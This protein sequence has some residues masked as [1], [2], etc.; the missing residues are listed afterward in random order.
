MNELKV[1][2][3]KEILGNEFCIYGTIEEPLFLAKDIS[4]W[5]ENKNPSQMLSIVDEEE[6]L[7]YTIHMSGQKRECWFLTEEGMY[8][9][10]MQSR[11]PIAKQIKKKIKEILKTIRKTGG[12]IPVKENESDEEILAKAFM[13][14]KNTIENQKLELQK[15]DEVIKIQKPKV[16][17]ADA[18]ST[19]KTSILIGDLAKLIKQ[20]G[21][22]IGQKRLFSWMREN[23]YLIKRKGS[24]YNSP[25][26]RSM[27]AEWFEIKETSITHSDGHISI[28]KTTKVTGKGQLYFINKF[29]NKKE[30]DANE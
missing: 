7:I 23:G 3:T 25:T 20:N 18:V 10:L 2:E 9:V 6:K 24:D 8:E 16:L 14:A 27:E 11:K 15:K 1:I 26:Q 13:I 12:Y 22:D 29:L 28:S 17:F 21:V 19:S 5:I 30:G 4:E